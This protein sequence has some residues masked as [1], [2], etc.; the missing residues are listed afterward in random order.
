MLVALGSLASAQSTET[1]ATCPSHHSTFNSWITAQHAHPD[2]VLQYC[3]SDMYLPPYPQ[4]HLLSFGIQ[5]RI[6]R[7]HGPLQTIGP[8]TIAPLRPNSKPSPPNSAVHPTKPDT[9]RAATISSV[10]SRWPNHHLTNSYHHLQTVRP[11]HPLLHDVQWSGVEWSKLLWLCIG[12]S[13]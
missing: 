5:S 6:L 1:K 10:T 13:S 9:P 4:Q 2:A 7:R 11:Y 8:T 3:A 12:G